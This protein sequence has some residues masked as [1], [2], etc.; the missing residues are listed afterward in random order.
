M[1]ATVPLLDM[2]RIAAAEAQPLPP[3]PRDLSAEEIR[4]RFPTDAHARTYLQALRWPQ[5]LECPR[6]GKSDAPVYS[7]AAN[8]A[9][10]VRAGLLE[11]GGCHRQFT[12]TVGTWFED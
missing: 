6:C 8:P 4:A 5:G 9:R 11:C 3:T 2:A 12:V 1:N 10:K 7:I